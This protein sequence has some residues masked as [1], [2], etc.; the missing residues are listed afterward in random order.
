MC[1]FITLTISRKSQLKRNAYYSKC[2]M[3]KLHRKEYVEFGLIAF[4]FNMKD[5]EY[6]EQWKNFKMS[7]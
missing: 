3:M 6:P 4:D 1:F 7:S 5:K 2:M